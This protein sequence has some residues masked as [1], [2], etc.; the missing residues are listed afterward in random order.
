M[1]IKVSEQIVAHNW[2]KLVMGLGGTIFQSTLWATYWAQRNSLAVP[3]FIELWSDTGEVLGVALAFH[4]R[5]RL[6]LLNSLT[7]YLR[8]DALPAVQNNDA[9]LLDLFMHLIE[10]QARRVG[11]V[12]LVVNSYGSHSALDVLQQRDFNYWKRLEFELD[13]RRSEDDLWEGLEYKRQKNIK[14]AMRLGVTIADLPS[15]CGIAELNRLEAESVQRAVG[16]GGRD[17]ADN[18]KDDS[19]RALIDSSYGRIVGAKLDG[20]I[21]SVGLFTY[22]NGLVYHHLSGHSSKALNAQAATLLVWEMIKGYRG[23]GAT[24]FNFGGCSWDAIEENSPEHGVYVYKKAF[25][26][27]AVECAS[28]VKVLRKRANSVAKAMRSIVTFTTAKSSQ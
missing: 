16:R 19:L 15:D 6:R 18:G 14:K 11:N 1:K 25:G 21:V 12:Q 26:A 24:R 5:S 4:E 2:D 23:L 27:T 7:K 10:L 17:F 13:L 28:G 22:F 3:Q 20:E 8:F 9:K